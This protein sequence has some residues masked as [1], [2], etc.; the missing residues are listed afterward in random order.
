MIIFLQQS[1]YFPQHINEIYKER[2]T[3]VARA[4]NKF[5]GVSVH[6]HQVNSSDSA[7]ERSQVFPEKAAEFPKASWEDLSTNSRAIHSGKWALKLITLRA[8]RSSVFCN[9]GLPKIDVTAVW[10]KFI[11]FLE[12]TF[13]IHDGKMSSIYDLKE[14]RFTNIAQLQD[15]HSQSKKYM[16]L[17]FNVREWRGY[18]SKET[19][20]SHFFSQISISAQV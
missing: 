2:T 14:V 17:P 13:V 15:S 8:R 9:C 18:T 7:L 16:K 1:N 19:S 3:Q 11:G 5:T 10:R 12:V 6:Y 4:G 20:M